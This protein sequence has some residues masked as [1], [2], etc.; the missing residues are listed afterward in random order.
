MV[1]TIYACILLF[2]FAKRTL[3]WHMA[4]L[5][6]GCIMH[7]KYLSCISSISVF[8]FNSISFDEKCGLLT[9]YAVTSLYPCRQLFQKL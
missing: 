7:Y 1:H 4:P 6:F 8:V 2:A 9:N 5:K 3:A